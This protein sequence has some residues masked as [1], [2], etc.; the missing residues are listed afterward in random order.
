MLKRSMLVTVYASLLLVGLFLVGVLGMP[1]ASLA[2]PGSCV[3]GPHSGVITGTQQWCASDSPHLLSGDVTVPAGMT[4]TVESNVTV[5]G[6]NG[7]ALLVE[8]YLEALGT[9]TEPITFTSSANTGGAQWA[10][11][12]FGG[13]SGHLRYV[14]VRYAGDSN[15]VSASVFNNG[16]YRSAVT[17]KDGT[18]LLENSTLRDTVSDS[19]D[20][21][22]LIDDATVII[23]DTV[24]TGIGN[25]ETRD[26]AMRVNGSDTVLEMHGCTFTG[27]TRDHVILEPGAMMGHDTT[28]YAQPVMDGYE[29]QADFLVPST[30]KLTLEP[31][32][33]MMGSSGNA[34]LV[35]G[36]LE[37]LGTPT[38]PITF[39]SS[40]DTGTGQWSGLGFDGGTGHLR[41]AT[42]RYAGQRNSITD[43][44][45]GHWA[46]AAVAMRDVLAGEVRFENVT[47]RDIAMADQDIGVYVENSNFIAADSLFT[48][49]G[50][51]S[52]Y[53]FPDTPLYIAGGDSD[54]AL[55]NNTF[56]A[57][58]FNNVVLQPGAMMNHP[59][60]LVPQPGLDGYVLEN[61]FTVPV[62]NT[63]TVEPGGIVMGANSAVELRVEGHL[64]A[65]GTPSLPVTFTSMTDSGPGQWAGIAIDG[66][67][68]HLR[69][70]IV[71][72]GGQRNSVSDPLLGAYDRGNLV[73]RNGTLQL[74]HV[75]VR[76]L[77]TDSRDYGL[78]ASDSYLVISDTLFTGIGGSTY[79]ASDVP[80]RLMGPDTVLEMSESY[81][82]GNINDRVLLDPGA[83]MGHDTTLAA[84]P[85]LD[86][87]E[88]R[89]DFTVPPSVTLTLEPGVTLMDGDHLAEFI[90]EGSLE[91]LG[92]PSQP[93]T[94]TSVADSGSGQWP[95]L[96]FDGGTGHLQHT[97]VRYAGQRNRIT[98]AGLGSWARSIVS[99]RDV[100]DGEVR[101]ESVT[102]SGIS[103]S[104][105]DLGV[106][107]ENSRVAI[108][109]SLFTG[110]GN[111][112]YYVFPDA[113]I[114]IAGSDSDVVLTGNTFTANDSNMVVLQAGAM[115]AHDTTLTKQIGLDGYLLESDFL[116]PVTTT[117][118]L[119]PGVTLRG[120]AGSDRAEL[121]VEGDLRAIGTP[122]QPITFTS[123]DDSAPNQWPGL[124]FEGS[125]GRGT[126]HLQYATVRY[127][128][129][130]NSVLNASGDY[131]AGSNVTVSNVLGGE[132]RLE[133]TTLEQEFHFDGWHFFLDHGLYVNNSRVSM[134]D[135]I[136][137]DNCD[138]GNEDSGVYV[139]GNSQVLID[140]SLIQSNGAL[141]LLV[142]GDTAFVK[143]TGSSI[144]NNTDD[145]VRNKGEATV[146]LSGDP[147]SAN[148]IHD[149]TGYGVNQ[150]GTSGQTIATYNWW[151][152]SSGPTHAGNPSGTGE[153]VTD[154]VLY[155]PW[156][157]EPP[158]PPSVAV[159]LVQGV[160]PERIPPGASAELGAFLTNVTTETLP[161]AVVV[162][163]LPTESEYI[164]STGD[165]QYWPQRHEV[166]WQLGDV[167]PGDSQRFSA[168][169]RFKWGLYP[170]LQMN[171]ITL[172]GADNRTHPWMALP[173][174]QS[175]TELKVISLQP[176]SQAELNAILAGDPEFAALY[177]QAAA[178]GFIY[179]G[180]AQMEQ[181]SDGSSRLVLVLLNV[182]MPGQRIDLYRDL[183]GSVAVRTTPTYEEV[184][185]T[186][187]G[188]RF[189]FETREMA[190]WGGMNS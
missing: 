152:D 110:I 157:T 120:G 142:E 156:L 185:T 49:I 105:G 14:T 56:T 162:A 184:Y 6:A 136:V 121:R 18:L 122:T 30:V 26:V 171:F 72:Y 84:Q 165:G 46:R 147:A 50:N 154:R 181:L 177:N 74:E 141:G 139:A 41:Y 83:M 75:V 149:N 113:P 34:L 125:A 104:N 118:T 155:D 53:V 131:H 109:D 114:Y 102:I 128:G 112:S 167:A 63:L 10:G 81:F 189:Y 20:H 164:Q 98:D 25:G 21:G 37:A 94:F 130:G 93:V 187:G 1:R 69:D 11:L 99:V 182:D 107:V 124:V 137:Q 28:L 144:V 175:Y 180:S 106:Y 22:L 96:A 169:V 178:D 174:Y 168:Q 13:G 62:S 76:D 135:S 88:F 148:A 24:F 17:V 45:F 40:T 119:S 95:G 90:I 71:R 145:G 35:E 36:E 82:T 59:A 29:F 65:L 51:G 7:K 101:L 133:H 27:S 132:V 73:I 77:V 57:N 172:G 61:D 115:M 179:Y 58:N 143:V 64:E 108:E 150:A 89:L 38:T 153:E 103:S 67:T 16:Y 116:V 60:S 190:S 43:A 86:G 127:G 129:R 31:G 138:S 117:L 78:I 100:M 9:A 186:T 173:E 4:L 66:G 70:A 163:H 48:A 123:F 12:A 134:A 158:T 111:G 47:I 33:T 176:V 8:G 2:A 32:V 159:K 97:T 87:Y 91:A 151:G 3:P 68:A 44:A 85:A 39:T 170:F 52:T 126:G 140:S 79:A 183:T 15:V 160:A 23:S 146:V 92:T 80:V 188:L 54:V 42:V 166:V 5:M 161:N 19:Y 55:T